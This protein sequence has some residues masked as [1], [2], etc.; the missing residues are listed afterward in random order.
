MRVRE[1]KQLSLR[2]KLASK[3]A[4]LAIHPRCC[5]LYVK[6]TCTV[7]VEDVVYVGG[8]KNG[9]M[10]GEAVVLKKTDGTGAFRYHIKNRGAMTAKGFVT[11]IQ[12]EALFTDGCYFA[13]AEN[14][15]AT[16]KMIREGLT[17]GGI[18][19]ASTSPT[20]QIF[21]RVPSAVSSDL[22][23]KFG[24][25][26]WSDEGEEAVLRIVTSFAT[27]AGDCPALV[28]YIV[29]KVKESTAV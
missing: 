13:L 3:H 6:D 9:A 21:I 8:T 22:M 2:S 25:E 4:Q 14:S 23:E 7:C 28:D 18:A 10:A 19:L 20:N 1:L 24:F 5:L 17:K 15:N 29:K 26:F 12:F 27:R 11:G 16:A